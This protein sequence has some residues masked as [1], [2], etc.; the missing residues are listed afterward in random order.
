MHS[1]AV[2]AV[3]PRVV[4]SPAVGKV[5]WTA[6]SPTEGDSAPVDPLR[7]ETY[8][9]RLGNHLVPGLSNRVQRVRY[10]SMVCAGIK[11]AADEVGTTANGRE[12]TRQVRA[13]FTRYEAAW[14][15]AQVAARGRDI[16]ERPEGSHQPRLRDE[17]RG[18]R[19][20]NRALSFWQRTADDALVDARGGYRL[21]QAQEAQGGLGAYLVAMRS[22]GFV[23]PDRLELTAAGS[24][25]A[26]AFLS[27]CQA[28]ARQA[29]SV[30]GRRPRAVWSRAGNKLLLSTPSASEREQVARALFGDRGRPLS[31]LVHGLPSSLRRREVTQDAFHHIAASNSDL[32]P[33]ASYALDFDQFR[34]TSLRMFAAVGT[35]LVART[36]PTK[37]AALLPPAELSGLA[38]DVRAA[39]A[40]VA[41][42]TPPP[43]LEPIA[44]LAHKLGRAQPPKDA[45]ADLV[46]F[47]RSEGRRWI[48]Q[49]GPHSYRTVLP[50]TFQDPGD[51]FHGFTLNAA[52]SV[53]EDAQP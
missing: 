39:A 49:A 13:R 30:D 3:A 31:R 52:L 11:A 19:G 12:H 24:R 37:L 29:L 26:A 50:G 48:E 32:A 4:T 42:R 43:G 1:S 53:Y 25:L 38:G 22:Y 46:W 45:F 6:W 27:G 44:V 28:D 10:F 7:F 16:K 40:A 51:R 17:F 35:S 33:A 9:E 8:A 15:F 47:H 36:A 18:F 5:Y 20:A 23:H 2:E 21:L 34:L 14:A 41:G